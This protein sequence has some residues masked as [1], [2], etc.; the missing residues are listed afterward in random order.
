ME[1]E[2]IEKRN[3]NYGIFREINLKK[4]NEKKRRKI[5]NNISS[6]NENENLKVQ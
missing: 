3:K 6:V 2:K 5:M 1:N 4:R